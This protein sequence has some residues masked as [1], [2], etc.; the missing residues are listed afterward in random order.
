MGLLFLIILFVFVRHIWSPRRVESLYK[1]LEAGQYRRVIKEAEQLIKKNERNHAAHYL[2]GLAYF[3][4][5]QMD[6]SLIEF[7]LL[8]RL[9]KYDDMVKEEDVRNRLAEIFLHFGQLEEAQKEFLLIAR[10]NPSNYDVMF[11]IAKIFFDRNYPENAHA[12]FNKVLA[13]NTKHADSHFHVGMIL[14]QAKRENEA[15]A[16]F[17]SAIK[18]DQRM[19]KASYYTG[20]INKGNN[21]FHQA[22]AAFEDAQKDP[23]FRQKARLAKGQCY[24]EVGDISKAILE[25]ERALKDAPEEDVV[26]LAMRYSLAACYEQIRD[27]PSAID[28]WE[29]IASFKPNYGDVL[30]KLSTYQEL[31]TDDKLK[32]FLTASNSGFEQMCRE[33][34]MALGYDIV[35]FTSQ[36][37]N[38]AMIL[39]TE[40]ESKWRNI[41]VSNKLIHIFR[42]SQPVQEPVVRGILEEMRAVNANKAICITSTKFSPGAREFASARPIDLID[43]QGLAKLLKKV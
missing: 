13:V 14:M 11:R 29:Q 7:K 18:Y 36:N 21:S 32:D 16:S 22:L 10:L 17:A 42:E 34:V 6:Q 27:L 5:K 43:K 15:L 4:S 2:L 24:Y 12:Y 19:H 28:Q 30:E 38:H 3:Y 1:V 20:M 39:G 35:K 9:N 40:P 23:E 26:T 8:T 41:K 31:R 33:L 37:G 25:F